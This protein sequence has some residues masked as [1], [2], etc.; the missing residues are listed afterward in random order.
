MKRLC[1]EIQESY[2]IIWWNT[3][4]KIHRYVL[5]FIKSMHHCDL[6]CT[7]LDFLDRMI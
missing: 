5:S 7:G 2:V 4:N 6:A 1:F 3:S